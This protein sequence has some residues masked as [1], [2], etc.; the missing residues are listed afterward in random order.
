ME[1]KRRTAAVHEGRCLP[2]AI[3]G[4]LV[5]PSIINAEANRKAIGNAASASC[6]RLSARIHYQHQSLQFI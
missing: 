2:L 3:V 4:T 6:R 5:P 1:S